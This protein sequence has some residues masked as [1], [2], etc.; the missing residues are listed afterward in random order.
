VVGGNVI[1]GPLMLRV[2]FARPIDIG[3]P[4][5]TGAEARWVPNI[6]LDWLYR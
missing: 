4:L 1:F 2:H 3:A 6:T 5:P